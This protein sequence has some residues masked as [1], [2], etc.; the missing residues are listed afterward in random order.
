MSELR[1]LKGSPPQII[2]NGI[3]LCKIIYVRG[4]VFGKCKII[5][6]EDV[7]DSKIFK[8]D[9][10]FWT[11]FQNLDVIS[12]AGSKI[13]HLLLRFKKY[14]GSILCSKSLGVLIWVKKV[15]VPKSQFQMSD[16]FIAGPRWFQMSGSSNAVSKS[17]GVIMLVPKVQEFLCWF[18]KSGSS[19]FSTLW[20]RN[21][22]IRVFSC[23][24]S[25]A[26]QW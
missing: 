10:C 6:P 16:S 22:L 1:S 8:W 5:Y 24:K 9:L 2:R 23:I 13:P 14:W 7:V 11:L 21:I 18:Q 4:Q 17:P 19:T 3:V 12:N 15:R 26:G 25:L 20:S